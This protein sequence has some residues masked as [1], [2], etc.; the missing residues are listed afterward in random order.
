MKIIRYPQSHLVIENNSGNKLIIDPG[1]ITFEKGFKPSKFQNADA[2]LITH[3][4]KDHL[5]LKNIKEIVGNKPVYTNKNVAIELKR[6][7]VSANVVV[8]RETINIAG[9]EIRPVYLPHVRLITVPSTRLHTG[10]LIN[11]I[12]F[13]AGDGTQIKNLKARVAAIPIGHVGISID[14]VLRCA[15]SLRAKIII[16]IHY[17]TYTR[18]PQELV[19]TVKTY[20][21]P[22]D[23]KVLQNG[24]EL[25]I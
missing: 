12:F 25:V 21:F 19:D 14:N 5:D 10:F 22:H 23:V 13:H 4:H 6:I 9:F 8:D 15:R 2:Y 3:E 7:G 17:E 11:K 18:N 20:G 16:P 1:Y 24:E